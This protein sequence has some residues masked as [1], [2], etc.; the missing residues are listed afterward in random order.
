MCKLIPD[1]NGQ[2]LD[3]PARTTAGRSRLGGGHMNERHP[4]GCAGVR[5]D[6]CC[7]KNSAAR[8]RFPHVSETATRRPPRFDDQH[9]AW[10][11]ALVGGLTLLIAPTAPRVANK[12]IRKFCGTPASSRVSGGAHHQ[13]ASLLWLNEANGI[14]WQEVGFTF[15]SNRTIHRHRRQR[16]QKAFASP[17]GSLCCDVQCYIATRRYP[18]NA[19]G[20]AMLARRGCPSSRWAASDSSRCSLG[21]GSQRA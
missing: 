14:L 17:F 5:N 1:G 9:P 3:L 15:L 2:E 6:S 18:A 19:A 7:C 20:Q 12:A 11:R 16:S 4:H 13:R 8:P 21:V 10:S